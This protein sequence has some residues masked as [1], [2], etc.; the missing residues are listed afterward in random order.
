MKTENLISEL[1]EAK[2][3]NDKLCDKAKAKLIIRKFFCDIHKEAVSATVMACNR[4][5][6]IEP[7]FF[8]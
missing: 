3:I 6:Y 7:N 4:Q 5:K 8:D 2:I 1:I